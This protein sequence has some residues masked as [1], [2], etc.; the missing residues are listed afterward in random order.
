MRRAFRA[1]VSVP[2][3]IVLVAAL[4]QFVPFDI[5][6]GAL[7]MAAFAIEAFGI[8]AATTVRRHVSLPRVFGCL[9]YHSRS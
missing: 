9:G 3:V 7:F 8:F 4:P 5:A 6:L 1:R 2:H